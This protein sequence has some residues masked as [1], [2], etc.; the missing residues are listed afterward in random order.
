ME[1]PL[2]PPL[3]RAVVRA[4]AGY[5]VLQAA[6]EAYTLKQLLLNS[7]AKVRTILGYGDNF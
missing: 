3:K 5:L 4:R 2:P 1:A 6:F 7:D